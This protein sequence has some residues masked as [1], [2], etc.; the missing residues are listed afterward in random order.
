MERGKNV[1]Q[2]AER[3]NPGD[4]SGQW[5]RLMRGPDVGRVLRAKGITRLHHANT[6]ATSCTFLQLGGLASR[7]HVADRGLPQ[8]PQY[9]D[10]VD[11]KFGIWYDVF[12]DTVDI[13][14]RASQRN[15]YGPVLFVVDVGILNDL[16]AQSEVFVTKKNPTKWIDGEPQEARFFANPGELKLSLVKGTF[17]Q[18]VV[19]KTQ[20]GI[21]PFR[22][23][24][25]QIV[26]DDPQRTL[27]NGT[28]AFTHGSARLRAA[29][30]GSGLRVT[31]TKRTCIDG[32]RCLGE[33]QTLPNFDQVFS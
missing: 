19:I 21:L 16:P 31:I 5:W 1:E 14:D 4:D 23:R 13:H 20:K 10:N 29:V 24:D 32:C 27:S 22:E 2:P 28:P 9:T 11:Q 17:D 12:T 6:V 15:Q 8:T 7:G 30:G 33:Y 3:G 18:I 25:V 26:L